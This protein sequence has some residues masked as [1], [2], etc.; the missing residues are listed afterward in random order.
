M[1]RNIFET[2][3]IKHLAQTEF[4]T[5]RPDETL[6]KVCSV[7][8]SHHCSSILVEA[9]GEVIGIWTERDALKYDFSSNE[10]GSIPVSE[11]MNSPVRYID[12]GL[13]LEEASV[14]FMREG[15]RHYVVL[16][17]G[18]RAGV[19]SL[20]DIV[21]DH[22]F[23][24]Y[25]VLR[26]AGSIINPNLVFVEADLNLN[27]AIELMRNSFTDA[28]AVNFPDDATGILTERDIIKAIAST[29]FQPRVGDYA[30][31][32]IFSVNEHESL[33]RA[34]KIMAEKKIRHLGVTNQFDG[35]IG[36]IA[37]SDILS[38]FRSSYVSELKAALQ[39]RDE[40]LKYIMT[41]L[42][43]NQRIIDTSHEGVMITDKDMKIVYCNQSLTKITGYESSEVIGN[44][45][46]LLKS[47]RHA[48]EFYQEMWDQVMTNDYWRGE[49]W[50]RRKNG[51]IYPEIL[52]ITAIR[53][54][55]SNQITHYAGFFSD[56]SKS[57]RREEEIRRL[58]FYDPLTGLPNRRLFLDRLQL[59]QAASIRNK[60][61]SA[62]LY[63]DL[64]NFK[65]IN[66]SL[67]HSAGDSVLQETAERFKV[68]LRENDTCA[69]LSGDEFAIILP[70]LDKSLE[71][72]GSQTQAIV[73][74]LQ[75]SLTRPFIV[76]KHQLVISPSIGITFFPESDESADE[77]LKQAAT[78]M[79]RAKKKGRN[80]IQFFHLE[81]QSAAIERMTL[82]KDLR[83]ALALNDLELWYQPQMDCRGSLLGA[84][85]LLRWRHPERGYVNPEKF[86]AVAEDC[87]L[88]H[89]LGD[90]VFETAF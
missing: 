59:E 38:G 51:E 69:R 8:T 2:L 29:D 4:L 81:M 50:N 71:T 84:E 10:S 14:Q 34:K 82:E 7:M 74:K 11:V 41:K 13:S 23:D 35:L 42:I 5:C 36:I 67:G 28:L 16:D 63:I 48:P 18:V 85:A 86:I 76:D 21:N 53:D 24:I 46:T 27:R 22:D 9:D 61:Y 58:T 60:K 80:Q 66:E 68:T 19:L 43:L 79:S 26:T 12:G 89:E 57:K 65:N 88:I 54:A 45:P 3:T 44:K 75:A 40:R 62:L 17:D 56:I 70:G 72:A 6:R 25:L 64:D 30:S 78:A 37:F 31:R 73:E 39:D 77:I 90:W 87:G 15:V 1:N 52:T 32:I 47:G 55:G 83:R 20:T 33:Y 49:I